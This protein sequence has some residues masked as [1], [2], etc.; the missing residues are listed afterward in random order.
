MGDLTVRGG[1]PRVRLLG[2]DGVGKSVLAA[3][4][5]RRGIATTKRDSGDAN[6]Y[7]LAGGLRATDRAAIATLAAGRT[8]LL[9]AWTKADAAGSWRAADARAA[10][11]AGEL[12]RP[13]LAVMALLDV[14]GTDELDIARRLAA[15]AFALPE[16]VAEAAA[17]LGDDA[18]VLVRTGGYGLACAIGALRETPSLS[19]DELL[20]RLHELSG[21]DLLAEPVIAA[22]AGFEARREAEFDETLRTVAR[23]DC[24]RRDE[25]EHLLLDRLA[26]VS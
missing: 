8:P 21:V 12:G 13:V 25:A 18:S 9:V 4:L 26:R 20:P 10:E 16:S 15:S 24:A 1:P 6:L 22:F 17:A 11:L 5:E 3:A 7:C 19:T 14:I 2:R 23:T